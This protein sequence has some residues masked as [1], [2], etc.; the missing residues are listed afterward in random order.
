MPLKKKLFRK[1]FLLVLERAWKNTE[2]RYNYKIIK[3][4]K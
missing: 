4:S 3:P 2:D 1:F